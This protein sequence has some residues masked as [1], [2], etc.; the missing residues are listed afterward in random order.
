MFLL[1]C[2]TDNSLLIKR[3]ESI[4]CD[5]KTVACGHMVSFY[6][7]KTKYNGTV[8]MISSMYKIIYYYT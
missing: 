7:R 4:I 8:R 6:H 3:N 1:E 5:Q 2:A